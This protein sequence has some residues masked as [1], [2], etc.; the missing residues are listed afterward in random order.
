MTYLRN[1]WT[2][3][4]WAHELPAGTLLART[5]LDQPLVLYRDAA[6]APRA[7]A[8]RCPHRFAPLSMGQLCDGGAS[9]FAL[10]PVLLPGDG[11]AARARRLLAALIEKEP[12]A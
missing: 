6:G 8:D 12:A 3:A 9:L 11:A 2:V 7:L 5:L 10:K 4:A 1:A